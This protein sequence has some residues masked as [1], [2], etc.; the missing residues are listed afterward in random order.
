ML[1]FDELGWREAGFPWL[2]NSFFLSSLFFYYAVCFFY[3]F[4]DSPLLLVPGHKNGSSFPFEWEV[5]VGVGIWTP[6]EYRGFA[7]IE[8]L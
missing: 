3:L 5:G 7:W 4:L 6:C 1:P 8:T 2:G